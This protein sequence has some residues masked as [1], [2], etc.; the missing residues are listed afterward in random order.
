MRKIVSI[1]LVFTMTLSTLAG[2]I[3]STEQDAEQEQENNRDIEEEHNHI[4]CFED[5]VTN[6]ECKSDFVVGM[7][8]KP[9]IASSLFLD[10]ESNNFDLH[11]HFDEHSH[12]NEIEFDDYGFSPVPNFLFAK[13][14][15]NTTGRSHAQEPSDCSS[16]DL[17]GLANQDLENYLITHSPGCLFQSVVLPL[18]SNVISVFTDENIIWLANRIEEIS[19]V[20]DG[21]NSEGVIQ[22]FNF[23][24]EAYYHEWYGQIE[25]F[26]ESTTEQVYS[27]INAF[28]ITPNILDSTEESR[29]ILL[30]FLWMSD[31]VDGQS[32]VLSI[33]EHVLEFF[34]YEPSFYE[35]NNDGNPSYTQQTVCIVLISMQ[36]SAHYTEV[37]AHPQIWDVLE[38]IFEISTS[39]TITEQAEY[40][41]SNAIWAF[42]RFAYTT[43]PYSENYYWTSVNDMYE[44]A[45]EFLIQAQN[46]HYQENDY[47]VPFLWAIKTHDTFFTTPHEGLCVNEQIDITLEE[48]IAELEQQLFS[49]SYS[50]DDERVIFQ[51]PLEEDEVISLYYSIKEVKSQYFR[52]TES[53]MPVENDPNSELVFKIYGTKEEYQTWQSF[54]YG[55]SSNN[56]GIYIEQWGT[57]FTYQRTPQESIYTLDDLV[58]HEYVHYL[59]GRYLIEEMWGENDFYDNSRLTW[60]NEGMA[61]FFTGS[62]SAKSVQ[63]RYV[64]VDRIQDDGSNRMTVSE[65]IGSSYGSGFKFYRY[66]AALIDFMYHHHNYELR[67][68]LECIN[69]D[70]TQCFDEITSSLSSDASFEDDY[71]NHIDEMISLLSTYQ[72]PQ[73][74]FLFDEELDSLETTYVSDDMNES[75]DN[76]Y[77]V[78][79][80]VSV[81]SLLPRYRCIGMLYLNETEDDTTENSWQFFDRA[82]NNVMMSILQNS[83]E[84][85]SEGM[86]CWFDKILIEQ[87]IRDRFNHSTSFHCEIPLKIA[88]YS[89]DGILTQLEEDVS[90]TRANGSVEC[91]SP[92]E[93]ISSYICKI[94]VFSEWFESGTENSILVTS[95]EMYSRE[96][97]NQIHS[98]NPHVYA[99]IV[100]SV[101]EDT[102]EYH[103]LDADSSRYASAMLGCQFMP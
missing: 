90:R 22:I 28:A 9:I 97:S 58:R 31:T 56:G 52:I 98:S 20:Y 102:L 21:D 27:A 35:L 77:P 19:D 14:D 7:G 96:I 70:D 48:A 95:L 88:Q 8:N 15:S 16:Q 38:L 60:I 86:V 24:N 99:N 75:T 37:N 84:R 44:Q 82:L 101:P 30:A 51:T 25:E 36:R 67:S 55:L 85:Y 68:M 62:T 41:V 18:D 29:A 71:Q 73:P 53:S 1:L 65:V 17:I 3:D 45:C 10:A 74:V 47:T 83:E 23:I 69:M 12:G 4:A 54:L 50:F 6:P 32:L 59:D 66:S 93:Q 34:P 64:I 57:V 11:D 42:G 89:A 103:E 81:R 78:D 63:P 13:T 46:F 79:C 92:T 5:L 100:C 2:C 49:N 80:D 26:D 39:Q 94:E 87:T 72:N 91:L 76:L 61:E 40:I 43:P 33:Y